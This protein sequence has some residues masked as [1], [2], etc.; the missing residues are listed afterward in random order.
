MRRRAYDNRIDEDRAI[1]ISSGIHRQPEICIMLDVEGGLSSYRVKSPSLSAP[2]IERKV[3]SRRHDHRGHQREDIWRR[4]EACISG[5]IN[6]K[7]Q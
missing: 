5:R 4:C 3:D 6:G 7:I 2:I 1:Y